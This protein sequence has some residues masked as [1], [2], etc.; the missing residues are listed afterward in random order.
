MDGKVG[1]EV[2]MG[3]SVSEGAIGGGPVGERA[4]NTSYRTLLTIASTSITE[5]FDR[6]R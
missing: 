1:I 6:R 2:A 4:L 3:G 5:S